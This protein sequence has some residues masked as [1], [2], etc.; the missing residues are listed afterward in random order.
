[1]LSSLKNKAKSRHSKPK[2]TAAAT[3]IKKDKISGKFGFNQSKS[4][5]AGK[6]SSNSIADKRKFQTA[7]VKGLKIAR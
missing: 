7:N 2:P 3:G 6:S 4:G 1:M 5:M